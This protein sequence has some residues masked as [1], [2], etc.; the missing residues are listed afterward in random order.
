MRLHSIKEIDGNPCLIVTEKRGFNR[1]NQI[2]RTYMIKSGK[3][4]NR[5]G[6][7]VSDSVKFKLNEI[8]REVWL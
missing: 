2:K 3:W 5:E 1:R 7:I 8:L 6:C 4:V